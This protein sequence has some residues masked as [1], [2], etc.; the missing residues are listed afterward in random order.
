MTADPT[1]PGVG[2]SRNHPGCHVLVGTCTDPSELRPRVDSDTANP[3]AGT[4]NMV[5]VDR[6]VARTATIGGVGTAGVAEPSAAAEGSGGGKA[7]LPP[8]RPTASSPAPT[9]SRTPARANHQGIG[10]IALALAR[11]VMHSRLLRP[12]ADR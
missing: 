4:R 2:P 10:P 9:R 6:P 3:M 8:R 5:G 12:C 11:E 7:R 1:W